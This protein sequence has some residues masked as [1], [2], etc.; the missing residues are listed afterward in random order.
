MVLVPRSK[1]FDDV[2][3]SVQDGLAETNHVFIK[4]NN[5]ANRWQ[6]LAKQESA[7]NDLSSGNFIIAETG[8]G[9]GLNFLAAWKL[10][11]DVVGENNSAGLEFISIEKYPLTRE[12]ISKVLSV[13]EN[14][15]GDLLPV[16]CGKYPDIKAGT[17]EEGINNIYRLDF[18]DY[19][20]VNLTL[21]I[22]DVNEIMPTLDFDKKIDAWFLDGF[23]PA[24]NPD[25]WSS[26]V[27]KNMARLSKPD[28]TTVATFTAAGAVRRGLSQHGFNVSKISGYG[29]KREMTIGTYAGSKEQVTAGKGG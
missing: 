21:H 8:F 3:F 26:E 23:K 20:N 14:D 4:G 24:S 16:F 28:S 22:G 1:R 9:T 15:L 25:M 7:K 12:Y 5:L 17:K 19:G 2:Y 6:E 18:C 27:F 11:R 29:R 10:W 13:W